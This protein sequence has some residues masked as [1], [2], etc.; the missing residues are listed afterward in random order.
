MKA[1]MTDL[2]QSNLFTCSLEIYILYIPKKLNTFSI[3][4]VRHIVSE[5]LTGKSIPKVM[6]KLQNKLYLTSKELHEKI[7][8][9]VQHYKMCSTNLNKKI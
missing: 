3:Y 6:K 1:I 5:K 2:S 7:I 8:K 4:Y 9:C